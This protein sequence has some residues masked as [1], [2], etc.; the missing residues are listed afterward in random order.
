[1]QEALQ[2]AALAA[3]EG[4]VP[5]GAVVVQ[6][7]IILARGRNRREQTHDPTA[8]AELVAMREAA[9]RLGS[10]RLTEA[11]V[12]VTL[13]PCPMCAGAMVQAR[14]RRVVYGCRDPKAGALDSLYRLGADPRLNHRFPHTGGV[15][16]DECRDLLRSFFR[17][18]RG[19]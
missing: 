16:E 3:A 13:E 8:H 2:E 12:V 11:T 15:L 19:S 7:G 5:V 1:M 10:W 18:R 6:D 9:R 4:E 17:A 14:V